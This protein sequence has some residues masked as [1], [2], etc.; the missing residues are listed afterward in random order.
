M[1]RPGA[2]D[3]RAG[4]GSQF[5]A[6]L[7]VESKFM[8]A[9]SSVWAA[10]SRVAEPKS[11]RCNGPGATDGQHGR[12][13]TKAFPQIGSQHMRQGYTLTRCRACCAAGCGQSAPRNTSLA[14]A[15]TPPRPAPIHQIAS[16][17]MP[18]RRALVDAPSPPHHIHRAHRT[19]VHS[20]DT[21][22]VSRTSAGVVG[23]ASKHSESSRPRPRPRSREPGTIPPPSG[24][25]VYDG[26][27]GAPRGRASHGLTEGRRSLRPRVRRSSGGAPVS[28][29]HRGE[30]PLWNP[31]VEER[32]NGRVSS[33][34]KTQPE[35]C[36]APAARISDRR[37]TFTDVR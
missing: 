3:P 37:R 34:Q 1:S 30:A 17:A 26:E 27:G 7:R 11:R 36:D 10:V 32:S 13:R 29:C 2:A 23:V 15:R 25:S 16:A 35:T 24:F 21:R 19:P 22:L 12:C 33:A 8:F 20:S 6:V 18:V 31:V 5:P 4:S 28:P 14:R 9:F